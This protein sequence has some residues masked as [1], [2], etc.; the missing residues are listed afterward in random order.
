MEEQSLSEAE[1]RIDAELRSIATLIES[2]SYKPSTNLTPRSPGLRDAVATA[3]IGPSAR[4]AATLGTRV[5]IVLF[6]AGAVLSSVLV[7]NSSRPDRHTAGLPTASTTGRTSTSTTVAVNPV[8]MLLATDTGPC[9]EPSPGCGSSA[10]TSSELARGRWSTFP[11]GPLSMR[12]S[13]VEVWTGQELIVWGGTTYTGK[14]LG[15]GASYDPATRSWRMLPASP[16]GAPSSA[17]GAWTGSEMI[18]VAGNGDTAS[19]D[20]A[21][22]S[23][24]RLPRF[25]LES[26]SG[27]TAL[28]TGEQL[29]V[30]GGEQVIGGTVV[31]LDDGA[32]FDPAYR[33]WTSLPAIPDQRGWSVTTLTPAWTGDRLILW[34]MWS[35]SHISKPDGT[36]HLTVLQYDLP[37]G[38]VGWTQ[39]RPPPPSVV[40]AA[41][42]TAWSGSAVLVMDGQWCPGPCYTPEGGRGWAYMPGGVWQPVPDY[43]DEIRWPAVWTGSSYV[44]MNRYRNGI[45]NSGV[46]DLA[47]YDPGSGKW[48]TLPS[49]PPALLSSVSLQ[50]PSPQAVWTG[51]ELLFWGPT[52]YSFIAGSVPAQPATPTGDGTVSCGPHF[53]DP[54]DNSFITEWYGRAQFCQLSTEADT[55]FDVVSNAVGDQAPGGPVILVERCTPTD[56][57]CLDPDAAHAL[58]GFT[59]Y[60]APDPAVFLAYSYLLLRRIAAPCQ[61]DCASPLAGGVLAVVSDGS[62]GTDVFDLRDDAW[63]LD[64]VSSVNA[65]VSHTPGAEKLPSPAGYR[66]SGRMP[67]P[68]ETV[69]SA[70]TYG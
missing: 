11:A 50:S 20:P 8:H 1:A 45:A 34:I 70:C 28:W 66:V 19:Y 62:C 51:A 32:A 49:P 18:V 10:G 64:S 7:L 21:T 9:A 65:L 37:A 2:W 47:A 24:S 4:R 42:G 23:W 58:R 26:R 68:P 59:A 38:A 53:F 31:G 54:S 61:F 14:G 40:T 67:P 69:P 46:Q 41:A 36:S 55:W 63:Y 27:A 6:V 39:G 44:T 16:L 13:E 48:A 3:T 56:A 29:V 60:R 15:D 17:V 5:A 12:H 33:D 22:N 30:L 57:S 52:S 35:V 25:P 43:F